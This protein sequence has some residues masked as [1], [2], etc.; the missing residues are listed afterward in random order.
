M[1]IPLA[2]K[3]WGLN[4]ILDQVMESF[5]IRIFQN[6]VAIFAATLVPG[7]H[8]NGGI[9]EYL[10]AGTLLALLNWLVKPIIKFVSLPI[11]ILTFGL[12]TIVINAFM[13]RIVDHW[14]E[15]INI[16]SLIALFLATVVVSAINMLSHK[17]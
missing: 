10:L 8:V 4:A 3:F 6:T 2:L 11:I 16:D 9:K 12:F 7:F 5:I 17:K 13:L 14:F 1:L 15:F